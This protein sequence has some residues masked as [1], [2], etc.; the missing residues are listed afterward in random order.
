MTLDEAL[1]K[2]VTV[3]C[4]CC[5]GM[6]LQGRKEGEPGYCPSCNGG[7]Y[8]KV[9]LYSRLT[10]EQ[11]VKILEDEVMRLRPDLAMKY[12]NR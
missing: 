10:N 2:E 6:S 4:Q 12:I 3:N 9:S 1:A 7:T 11:R 5:Q 8:I